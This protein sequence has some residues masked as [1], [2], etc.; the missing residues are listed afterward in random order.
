MI[1]THVCYFEGDISF[2]N[3]YFH[4]SFILN[5]IQLQMFTSVSQCFLLLPFFFFEIF[6]KYPKWLCAQKPVLKLPLE[7]FLLLHLGSCHAES[8]EKSET[9]QRPS[10]HVHRL[11][12]LLKWTSLLKH[13]LFFPPYKNLIYFL[14]PK[15]QKNI[16]SQ[17]VQTFPF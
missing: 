2:F 9:D 17:Y 6:W 3:I 4:I 14:Y 1:H 10:D 16:Y 13:A 12:F 15:A 7:M 11:I 8:I 5:N